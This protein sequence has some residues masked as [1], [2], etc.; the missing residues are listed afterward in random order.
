MSRRTQSNAALVMVLLAGACGLR[1]WS[2]EWNQRLHGDVNLFALTARQFVRSGELA[3]PIKY[4]FSDTVDYCAPRSFASQHPPLFPLAAGLSSWAIGTDE[5]FPL[6]KFLSALGGLVLLGVFA[7]DALSR[8][9]PGRVAALVFVAASPSLV[10]FSSN[11]SPYI[12][13]GVLLLC[14]SRLSTRIPTAGAWAYVAAGFVA[15]IG[16]QLHTSLASIPVSLILAGLLEHRHIDRRRAAWF[17]G[18]AGVVAAPYFAWNTI[19]FGSPL[20]SYNQHILW[21]NLGL[22]Q[23]GIWGDVV[24]WRWV[25]TSWWRVAR[26]VMEN[27]REGVRDLGLS[28]FNDGG[29]GAALLAAVGLFALAAR[30]PR[31]MF[32]GLLPPLLYVGAVGLLPFRDRFAVPL[33]PLAYLV[34]SFGLASL[35]RT[36]WRIVAGGCLLATVAWMIPAYLEAPP[37]RY[38]ANDGPHQTAYRAMAP[39][40][41]RFA[42]FPKAPT[43]ALSQALDGGIE[44]AYFHRH[45]LIRGQ[46]HGRWH[47][48][49]PGL[50]PQKLA[51]DF[52]ARYVWTDVFSRND[53]LTWFPSARQIIG[54][55]NF[56]VFEIPERDRTKPGACDAG[57]S[58]S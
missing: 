18:T 6:L 11:G 50:V 14:A 22:A 46:P 53:V 21:T 43:L 56:F 29:P 47:E 15:G 39:V 10:D 4:E 49:A 42:L 33:L 36:R 26:E 31:R 17:F 57:A 8:A 3:Y 5:T 16:P 58:P 41:R 24:T 1:L 32:R 34:A 35:W 13:S 54:D 30:D 45:P 52:H 55:G 9:G 51:R 2:L 27:A 7:R 28:L 37:T 20:Y 12:W 25:D 48:V 19:H 40:A 23:E 38:Y 44:A